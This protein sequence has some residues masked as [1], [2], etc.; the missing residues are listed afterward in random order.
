[1]QR[2]E[3][4]GNGKVESVILK[5]KDNALKEIKANAIFISIGDIPQTE[6]CEKLNVKLTKDGYIETDKEQK[7]NIENVYSAGDVTG[8]VKQWIVAC[9]EG[10]IASTTAFNNMQKNK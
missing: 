10:A 4:K 7:T 8:G 5:N 9:G 6:L 1:M 2:L 3:I